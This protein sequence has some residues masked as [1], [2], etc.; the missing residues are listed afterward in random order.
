[1]A[2]LSPPSVGPH[3]TCL[4]VNA[5]RASMCTLGEASTGFGTRSGNAGLVFLAGW[6]LAVTGA[7]AAML[8][9]L[10]TDDFDGLN[11]IWQIPF[12][13]PWFLVPLPAITSWSY[14]ADAWAVA[15][16]GWMN[17]FLLAAWI[18]RCRRRE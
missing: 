8:H 5:A 3:L 15:V 16:M 11:N 9:S 2:S 7:L 12:A 14:E 17:G 4:A 18:R 6:S 13:L 1:M 10:A